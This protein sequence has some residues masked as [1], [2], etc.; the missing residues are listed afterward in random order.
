MKMHGMRF[1]DFA[2]S[3][4]VPWKSEGM[5]GGGR[6]FLRDFGKSI[7]LVILSPR[8]VKAWM[9]GGECFCVILAR[10]LLW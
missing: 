9:E 4:L 5:D 1:P 3:D 7:A 2:F 6:V 8:K 10:V